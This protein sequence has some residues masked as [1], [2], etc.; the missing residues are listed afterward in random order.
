MTD[1]T[2]TWV[3]IGDWHTNNVGS[4][5]KGHFDGQGHRIT[6]FNVTTSQTYYGIF[7]VVSAATIENFSIEGT[8]TNDGDYTN[9]GVVGYSRDAT[10][11]IRDIQSYLTI[12]NNATDKN[13]SGIL[14]SGNAGTTNIDR[15]AFFGE[16]IANQKTN[17]GGIIGYFKNGSDA[18]VNITNCLFAGTITSEISNS[19]CGGMA[20]YGGANVSSVTIT[21]CLSLGTLEAPVN[22]Q[23]FG[24]IRNAGSTIANCYYQG[25][26]TIGNGS[27]ALT[28]LEAT[29][30][31][32]E[33]LESGKVCYL[34]N[35]DQTAI[36][37]YQ[38]IGTDDEPTL[39]NA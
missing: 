4:A 34:L 16:I 29:A 28:N 5:F 3:P 11:N 14:G 20:G 22:G 31:T 30:V 38:T 24:N 15:C 2:D 32:D 39:D 12:T 36:T 7:G 17:A 9:I 37:W 18:I 35:G 27:T 13:V 1:I 26:N 8:I 6:N 33:Q 10:T 21:N 25:D 19:Y 23:F